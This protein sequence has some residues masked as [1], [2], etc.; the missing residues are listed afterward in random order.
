[1]QAAHKR[2]P[3]TEIQVSPFPS[4]RPSPVGRGGTVWPSRLLTVRVTQLLRLGSNYSLRN[5][6]LAGARPSN[7]QN[8]FNFTRDLTTTATLN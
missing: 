4:P 7:Y 6:G 2:I 3:A 5:Q 1:M 8:N